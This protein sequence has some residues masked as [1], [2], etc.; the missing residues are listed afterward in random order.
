MLEEADE[1]LELSVADSS[2]VLLSE[3]HVPVEADELDANP[4]LQEL[5]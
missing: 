4:S 1:P 3:S 5:P 2:Q